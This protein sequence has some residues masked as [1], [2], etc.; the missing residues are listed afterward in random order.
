MRN[1]LDQLTLD[2][3]LLDYATGAL[4]QAESLLMASYMVLNPHARGQVMDYEA[5]GAA[6]LEHLEP[7][8]VSNACLE[9]T[10]A[11]LDQMER[12][13]RPRSRPTPAEE[14]ARLPADLMACLQ[15]GMPEQLAWARMLEGIERLTLLQ[16]AHARQRQE[17]DLLRFHPGAGFLRQ[18]PQMEITL[19]IQGS[20]LDETGRHGRGE[21]V[22]V[23]TPGQR[24]AA[25]QEGC[26]TLTL[27]SR[28][29]SLEERFLQL[30]SD[31]LR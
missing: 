6:M 14:M 20:Y 23:Q 18:R 22:I 26:L 2:M 12:Q 29:L 25:R 28:Q 3:L 5:L 16:A 4:S 24:P 9:R 30:F 31:L 19:V 7:V 8:A 27:T 15:G 21:I 17:L 1:A 13:S 11:M 10:L